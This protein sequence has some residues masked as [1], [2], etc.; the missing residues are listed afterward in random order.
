MI[1]GS[2][3]TVYHAYYIIGYSVDAQYTTTNNRV[4]GTSRGSGHI[5]YDVEDKTF[6]E[7]EGLIRDISKNSSDS[8]PDYV[9]DA[10][11]SDMPVGRADVVYSA[12]SHI[13]EMFSKKI[14][15]QS[16]NGR[17]YSRVCHPKDSDITITALSKVMV[18][19]TMVGYTLL[20][21]DYEVGF[22]DDSADVETVY[23]SPHGRCSICGSDINRPFLCT[24]CGRTVHKGH[25]SKKHM[26]S[27]SIC[28]R[29]MCSL[30]AVPRCRFIFNM[31]LCPSCEED[32]QS[33]RW[34][35]ERTATGASC[36]GAFVPVRG[37]RP[38]S[39]K[40]D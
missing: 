34:P 13:S 35:V 22:L 17:S 24:V 7:N 15:W 10:E 21:T 26:Q 19:T 38:S 8:R 12:R 33:G 11:I 39:E 25:F 1:I 27:C 28:G 16:A 6:I 18:A 31:P 29:T 23:G 30:C 14:T 36:F 5:L 2:R 40:L 3:D 37:P 9:D 20:G 32:R 4:I